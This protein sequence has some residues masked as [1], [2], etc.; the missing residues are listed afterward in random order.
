MVQWAKWKRISVPAVSD[1]SK[2][3]KIFVGL[4]S[5]DGPH[6]LSV[7][8]LGVLC[9]TKPNANFLPFDPPLCTGIK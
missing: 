5:V 2:S 6:A 1:Q 3:L 4:T 9:E 8:V 7:V